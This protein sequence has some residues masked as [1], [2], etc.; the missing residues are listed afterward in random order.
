MSTVSTDGPYFYYLRRGPR[1]NTLGIVTED[2][3]AVDS[4]LT[5]EIRG[6][7]V[8]TAQSFTD[9]ATVNLRDE[10]LMPFINGVLS[11]ILRFLTGSGDPELEFD[12]EREKVKMRSLN[13]TQRYAG[14]GKVHGKNLRSDRYRYS[15]TRSENT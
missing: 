9:D 6:E 3:D 12:F 11:S 7:L 14:A 2:G 5:V 1:V 4:G 13:K 8:D 10:S 15:F